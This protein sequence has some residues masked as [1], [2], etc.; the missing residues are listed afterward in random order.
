M[1]P[2]HR[3][4]DNKLGLARGGYNVFT[5]DVLD[6]RYAEAQRLPFRSMTT[7]TDK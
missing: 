5:T 7:P 1:T 4:I 3:A 2:H 6:Y